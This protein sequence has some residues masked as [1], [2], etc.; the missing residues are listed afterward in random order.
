MPGAITHAHLGLPEPIEKGSIDLGI[1]EDHSVQDDE[2][3]SEHHSIHFSVLSQKSAYASQK[4][5]SE[6]SAADENKG[7]IIYINV[8][9][10]IKEADKELEKLQKNNELCS[11]F[12]SAKATQSTDLKVQ[13]GDLPGGTSALDVIARIN[14]RI[15]VTEYAIEHSKWMSLNSSQNAHKKFTVEKSK[16]H[17]ELLHTVLA[18]LLIPDEAYGKFE[19]ILDSISDAVAQTKD[20]S[21]D[22]N[23]WV[24]LTTYRWDDRQRKVFSSRRT[25]YFSVSQDLRDYNHSKHDKGTEANVELFYKQDDWDF[26]ESVWKLFK[27]DVKKYLKGK[28]DDID[29]PIDIPV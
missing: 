18:G 13:S 1:K 17:K 19:K 20:H 29:K 15:R 24:I 27:S 11:S 16:L 5:A 21:A 12:W 26:N 10:K 28:D 7:S 23:M 6:G 8:I 25:I 4:A 2:D 9:P 14:Y 22:Q 3:E